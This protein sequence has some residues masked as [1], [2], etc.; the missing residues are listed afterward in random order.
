MITPVRLLFARHGATVPNLAGLRCGGDVDPPL[1]DAG[2]VQAERLARE[3]AARAEPIELIV[4][5]DLQ[6]AHATA[7]AVQRAVHGAQLQVCS[8]LRE[9]R[10]GAWNFHEVE[11]TEA[12]MAAG[13]TPPGGESRAAFARRIDRALRSIAPLAL[14]HRTL[15]VASK[16]VARVLGERASQGPRRSL[17]NGELVELVLPLRLPGGSSAAGR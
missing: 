15:I 7:L 16:G 6:R 12:A 14:R 9:R 1:A 8:A 17:D 5:S 4:T 11:A 13:E 10:L 3:V 2:R